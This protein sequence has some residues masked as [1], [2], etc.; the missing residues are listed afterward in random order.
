[1]RVFDFNRAIVRRPGRSIVDGLRAGDHS[2]PSYEGVAREH[3]VYLAAL[4][5]AGLAITELPPLE[6][7][8]DSIFVEDPALVF[9]EG[10]IL[11]R[12][13]VPTRSGEAAELE[14]TLR[15][16]FPALLELRAG[17]ADG[18]DIL[19]TPEIVFIGLS[20]RTDEEGAEAVARLLAEFGRKTRVVR[21]PAGT[22]HLKSSASLIDEE[23]IL[24]TRPVAESGLF[25]GFRVL[26]VA[27][28]EEAGANV[29]RLNDVV[30]AGS[31][32]P[33]TQALL[34]GQGLGLSLV[35]TEQIAR[36]DAG[37][38]CMSL[39]WHDGG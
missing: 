28:G 14:P 3:G 30:I 19:V 25:D 21:P 20:D 35:P 12:P 1:M 24:T 23:T 13:G 38:T 34:E 15:A 7:Y 31:G 22:L 10:A 33:R 26:I 11:L 4:A 5:G 9:P 17:H 29:L 8:P 36:I 27:E 2:G 6:S 32:F 18:G 39:R 16:A 37:L